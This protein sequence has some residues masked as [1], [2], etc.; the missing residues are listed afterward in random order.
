MKLLLPYLWNTL[1]AVTYGFY[2]YKYIFRS[3]NICIIQHYVNLLTFPEISD[4]H[5]RFRHVFHIANTP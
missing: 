3:L 4:W 5:P 1:Y 2:E